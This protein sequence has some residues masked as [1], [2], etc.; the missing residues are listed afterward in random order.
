MA[1][2]KTVVSEGITATATKPVRIFVRVR[3]SADP[4]EHINGHLQD[5]NGKSFCGIGGLGQL[6]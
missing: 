3:F 6:G 2:A 5:G 4:G 1:A